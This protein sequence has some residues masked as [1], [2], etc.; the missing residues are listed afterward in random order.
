M[1]PIYR[2][3]CGGIKSFLIPGIFIMKKT[4]SL[5]I[6]L[7]LILTFSLTGCGYVGSILSDIKGNLVGNEYEITFYDNYGEKPS[8]C[9][10]MGLRQRLS[11]TEV[12]SFLQR[13]TNALKMIPT[14]LS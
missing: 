13:H 12:Y 14:T 1:C 8:P 7:S 6:I 9:P 3:I 5:M 11:E 2:S 4:K 10:C